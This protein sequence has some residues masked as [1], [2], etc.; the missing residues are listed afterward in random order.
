VLRATHSVLDRKPTPH[1]MRSTWHVLLIV[2]LLTT[3]YGAVA[4]RSGGVRVRSWEEAVAFAQAELGQAGD[5]EGRLERYASTAAE[6][7]RSI[8]LLEGDRPA[9]ALVAHLRDV[10]VPLIGNGW[11]ILLSLLSLA[12]VDG[13]RIVA[14][15]EETLSAATRLR[16][17]LDGLTGLPLVA[18][19]TRAFRDDPSPRSLA[20]L[21]DGSKPATASLSHLQLELEGVMEPLRDAAGGLSGLVGGLQAAGEAGIPVVSDAA[22]RAGEGIGQIEGPLL[23]LRDGLERLH[24][25]I[26]AD[27]VVLERLQEAVRLAREHEG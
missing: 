8:E 12:T 17:S 16:D 25:E 5:L 4:C 15:L 27:V 20:E 14:R 18:E 19:A 26:D 9:L 6:L 23:E 7:S 22:R 1:T 24:A 2:V 11:Q 3:L 10:D 13:A 21:A